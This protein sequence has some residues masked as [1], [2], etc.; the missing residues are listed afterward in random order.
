MD[1]RILSGCS[2]PT[3]SFSAV[4]VTQ[5]C[6]SC[7]RRNAFVPRSTAGIERRRISGCGVL[8]ALKIGFNDSVD[9]HSNSRPVSNLAAAATDTDA[10]AVRSSN[11]VPGGRDFFNW[12]VDLPWNRVGVWIVVAWFV[13][14][15]KDFFGVG[16][17]RL[18]PAASHKMLSSGPLSS[19]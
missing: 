15:L 17:A 1:K 10:A 19:T 7:W 4:F 18:F 13:Y 3:M 8:K 11:P 16:Q 12:L 5:D 14:Q 6:L 9:L 2:K